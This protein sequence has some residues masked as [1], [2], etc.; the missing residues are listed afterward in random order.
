MKKPA[1]ETALQFTNRVFPDASV[2]ILAGSVASGR[3]TERSDLDLLMMDDT[4]ESPFHACYVESGWLIEAFVL[5]RKSYKKLYRLNYAA[6]LGSLQ[7]MCAEGKLI[8]DDGSGTALQ[9]EALKLFSKGPPPWSLDDMNRKRYEITE[10]LEGL[11]YTMQNG[12]ELFVAGKLAQ[13]LHEFVLRVNGHWVGDGKWMVRALNHFDPKFCARY[14]S[15]FQRFY[16]TGQQE[17]LIHLADEIL[18][19][20]G[21]RLFE[22]FRQEGRG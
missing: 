6:G 20:F 15:T 11:S 5:T 7:R 22:G 14:V 1:E 17:E 8:K 21:G 2:I 16:K 19:P 10:C 13:L 12:E 18:E 3:M 9:A 4:Q